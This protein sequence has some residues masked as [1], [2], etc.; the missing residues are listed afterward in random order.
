M[1]RLLENFVSI[2]LLS[3]ALV[4]GYLAYYSY[5]KRAQLESQVSQIE[6]RIGKL[7]PADPDRIYILALDSPSPFEFAWRICIP[8]NSNLKVKHS[9]G[10][11][12][13]TST[14]TESTPQEF[15]ARIKI[16]INDGRLLCKSRFDNRAGTLSGANKGALFEAVQKNSREGLNIKIAGETSVQSI[17]KTDSFDLLRIDPKNASEDSTA[18]VSRSSIYFTFNP[19]EP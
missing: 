9:V 6:A 14:Y 5:Q 16:S 1:R 13:S 19:N 10:Q 4:G 11:G 3:V 18:Q 15:I 12:S 17:A 7:D 8:S 2:A